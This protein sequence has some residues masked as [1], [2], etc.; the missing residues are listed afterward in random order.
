LLRLGYDDYRR[1]DAAASSR[2][3]QS[4]AAVG[5]L[6]EVLGVTRQAARKVLEGLGQ[7]QLAT[8]E[9]D[10]TTTVE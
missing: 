8:T 9:R 1:S 10:A 4:P 6:G 7:R 2:L 5:R 3:L